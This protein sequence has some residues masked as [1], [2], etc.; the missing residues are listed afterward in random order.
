M[1]GLVELLFKRRLVLWKVVCFFERLQ[2]PSC[3]LF[4]PDAW[5]SD[6]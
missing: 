3:V 2:S 4:I 6:S 5:R 1:S